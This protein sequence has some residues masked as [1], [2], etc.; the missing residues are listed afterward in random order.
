MRFMNV[1]PGATPR[2]ANGTMRRVLRRG[3]AYA[4]VAREDG[5]PAG[6]G[7]KVRVE[8]GDVRMSSQFRLDAGLVVAVFLFAD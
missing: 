8:R 2:A 1:V 6:D 4:A 5:P 3:D 7:R